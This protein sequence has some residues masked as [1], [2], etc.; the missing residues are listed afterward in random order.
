MYEQGRLPAFLS[1]NIANRLAVSLL[2]TVIIQTI[3]SKSRFSTEPNS[4]DPLCDKE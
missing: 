1:V 4:C 3:R 2:A